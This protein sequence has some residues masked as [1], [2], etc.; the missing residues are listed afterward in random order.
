ML[1]VFDSLFALF[2]IC[3]KVFNFID[4]FKGLIRWSIMNIVKVMFCKF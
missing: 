4:F 1:S 3:I 2:D